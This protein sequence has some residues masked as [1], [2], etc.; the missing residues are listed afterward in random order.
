MESIRKLVFILILLTNPFFIFSQSGNSQNYYDNSIFFPVAGGAM[1]YGLYGYDNPALLTSITSY[2]FYFSSYFQSNDT[3]NMGRHSF[4]FATK[5]FGAA[6]IY[7]KNGALSSS[8]V[9]SSLS[10]GDKT[11]SAGLAYNYFLKNYNKLNYLNSASYGI[12]YRPL[13]YFS[14]GAFGRIFESK[15]FN[16]YG[17][18]TAIRPFGN[19]TIAIFGDFIAKEKYF[20]NEAKWS[21]GIVLEP[22]DGIRISGR[23]FS[24]KYATA[25]IQLSLGS[26][27]IGS[28]IISD[29]KNK[30]SAIIT[31][32]R[33]GELDRS[34][35]KASLSPQ[36]YFSLN[37]NSSIKERKNILLDNSLELRKILEQIRIAKTDK[38]IGAIYIKI[39]FAP[40]LYMAHEIRE[41]LKE[42]KFSNKKIIVWFNDANLTAY[43]L[44]SVAD[45]IIMD[46]M[47]SVNLQGIIFGKTYYKRAL[48]K[49]GIG[50]DEWR[51]YKYKSAF[52]TVSRENLSEADREQLEKLSDDIFNYIIDEICKSR[53]FD[54]AFFLDIIDNK[55]LTTPEEAI[56]LKLV[57]K[58]SRD[59]EVEKNIQK[60]FG[61][62][63]TS[64][65]EEFSELPSDD[66][67]GER[68]KIAV[69]FA[70]GG[71]DENIGMKTRKIKNIIDKLSNDSKIKAIVLRVNSPGGQAYAA[72][73]IAEA[74]KK[75]K[76]NKKI[77]II[78][79]A[80]VAAS[81]G[82]WISMNGDAI[83]AN[84]MTITGS[85]GVIGGWYYDNGINEK[86]G[87]TCDY[88]KKGKSADLGFGATYPIL[89]ITL[90][91]RNLTDSEK[92]RIKGYFD[93]AYS[94]FI[95]K[96]A[97]G[98]N[99]STDEI[100]KIAQG[101]IWSG[102]EAKNIGLVDQIGGLF[103]AIDYARKKA[104]LNNGEY[105][106]VF[107]P[108][109][110]LFEFLF[111][112][113]LG[114][115]GISDPFVEYIKLRVKFNGMP[116]LLTPFDFE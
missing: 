8:E 102:L 101:R 66:Y 50:V 100:E 39:A 98:R 49:L 55:L 53:G 18:E 33:I 60:N 52:E 109:Q 75:A 99:K 77:V 11:I 24:N 79:Q 45:T 68:P 1:K 108:E 43:Y 110:D 72:D 104:N 25:G 46:P 51:Y 21:A 64:K 22:L 4:F 84:P 85:I 29:D 27:G 5:N 10:F 15:N 54:K 90:P 3:S 36:K 76:E 20:A 95:S 37:I 12:I 16:Y 81:G 28:S 114:K 89:N 38:N 86:L 32:L 78:S 26:F 23:Y 106:L 57:D 40:S 63:I 62:K 30:N 44:A 107:Y 70:L 14:F 93:F 87:F 115:Q 97:A 105:E 88:V 83:F 17:F 31:S 34:F 92:E 80:G 69:I 112:D 7:Y 48:D 96:A 2:D 19:Q 73:L 111:E 56:S 67:W 113:L 13:R 91:S 58:I 82:Y 71:V 65:D 103:D 35:L 61:K 59:D 42:F 116:M 47:G 94:T 41:S 9:S 74:I 6:Y